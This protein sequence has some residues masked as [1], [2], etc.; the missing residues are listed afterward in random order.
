VTRW[1]LWLLGWALSALLL[2]GLY[3]LQRRTRDATAVDAGWGAAR[4]RSGC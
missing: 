2:L 4:C 3:L 1:E